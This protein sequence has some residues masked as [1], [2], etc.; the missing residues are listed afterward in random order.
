MDCPTHSGRHN[1]H[2][3]ARLDTTMRDLPKN[4]S[5]VGRHKCTYCAYLRGRQDAL[6][7]ILNFVNGLE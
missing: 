6:R 3:R 7:E 2:V 5:G 1:E 4:Q